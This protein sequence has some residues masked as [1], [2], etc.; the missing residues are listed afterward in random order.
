MLIGDED[1]CSRA[2]AQSLRGDGSVSAACW[3][4]AAGCVGDDDETV[5]EA[6][7][8]S[9]LVALDAFVD[10]L[11]AVDAH[12]RRILGRDEQRVFVSAVAGVPS[13]FPERPQPFG[14]GNDA[15][16]ERAFG[17]GWGCVHSGRV[18]A[19]SVRVVEAAQAFDPWISNVVSVCLEDWRPALAC[20]PGDSWEQFRPF[21]LDVGLLGEEPES[22][23]ACVL[24]ETREGETRRL[25]ECDSE[26]S[27]EGC[28]SSFTIPDG[29]DACVGWQ[30]DQALSQLCLDGGFGAEAVVL[31]REASWDSLEYE[32]EC[33]AEL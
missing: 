10:R 13:G 21:C 7:E 27:G 17:T 20:L 30:T 29:A 6:A 9:T 12:K 18:A 4:E 25:P 16:F 32:V 14:P 28:E 23:D 15:E 3:R 8:G 2:S 24:V 26:C 11:E 22:A 31:R 33:A 19:P 1:D 5:C